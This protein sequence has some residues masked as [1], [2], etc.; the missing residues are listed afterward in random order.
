V[1]APR[2]LY[3]DPANGY[4]DTACGCAGH[5]LNCWEDLAGIRA[6]HERLI[7]AGDPAAPPVPLHPLARYCSAYCRGRAKRD[8][9]L[10]RALTAVTP[11]Q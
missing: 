10:D 11:G 3:G 7:A 2:Y 4:H 5:C 8:R 1:T 9:A 6:L